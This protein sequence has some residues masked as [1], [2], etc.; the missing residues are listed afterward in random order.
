MNIVSFL[1]PRRDHGRWNPIYFDLLEV[2]DRSCRKLGLRHVVLTDDPGLKSGELF[3]REL[4]VPLMMAATR[5]QLAWVAGGDWRGED[6]CFVGADCLMLQDP[7]KHLA[8]KFEVAVT[9]RGPAARYPINNG[10]VYIAGGAR[11]RALP[12]FE[13]IAAKTGEIWC[14][15]QRAIAE[16]LGPLPARFGTYAR[17]GLDRVGF[18]PMRPFNERPRGLEAM[19]RAVMLHFRGKIERKQQMLDW[20]RQWL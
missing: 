5:A 11:W 2:L 8:G 16:A 20:A 3:C 1:A 17:A 19:P 4:P 10:L 6:T 7:G 12:L 13:E 14:D 15:D 18:V 9:Y